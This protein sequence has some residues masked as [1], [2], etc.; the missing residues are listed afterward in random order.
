MILAHNMEA[1]NALRYT[2]NSNKKIKNSSEK[3]STGYKINRAG[4]NAAGLQISEK[5][6]AQI[7]GLERASVNAQDGISFVQT[8]DGALNDLQALIQRGRELCVQAANDT[9][10]DSDRD[11]LQKEID[12]IKDEITRICEQS[13]FN[14]IRCFPTGGT[15]PS[16]TEIS[17][18]AKY[19]ITIDR[20]AGTAVVE[21]SSTGPYSK[22][23]DKI[24]NELVPNASNQILNAFPSLDT[25]DRNIDLTF[26]LTNIDGSSGTLAYAQI[27]Y[28]LSSGDIT[29]YTLQVDISDFTN[30]DAEGT[31]P[32]AEMLESTIAH[33]MMHEVMYNALTDGMTYYG[34]ESFPNWFVEGTAQVAGGGFTTGWNSTL[35]YIE[36]SG[37]TPEIKNAQVEN[38][39][40]SYTP[41]GRP[42][43]HGYLA[44]AYLG[45]LASGEPDVSA[46]SISKGL[47]NIFHSMIADG[48]SLDEA[49][50]ANTA[51]SN[52]AAVEAAFSSPSPG[53]VAFVRELAAA[54]GAGSAIAASLST[55]GTDILNDATSGLKIMFV[56]SS[57]TIL[58]PDSGSQVNLSEGMHLQIGANS[59]QAVSVRMYDISV[60][61]LGLNSIFVSDHISADNAIDSY[62]S[63]L[64]KVSRV[65]SYYGAVQNRLEHAIA[66]SDN[67]AE[68]LQAAESGIRDTDMAKEMV[69]YSKYNILQQA[70]QAMLAQANQSKQGILNLLQ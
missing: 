54:D 27:T 2:A 55:K 7:R 1:L 44:S 66:N 65:R 32:R 67:A 47:D 39:L 30:A 24:A 61:T 57:T 58:P 68:N 9:N 23:A 53:L 52:A 49:I 63:A 40:K 13:E 56:V 64:N 8:T 38:Y 45:Y 41:S 4:D 42:Y 46:A 51:F 35:Q 6:R 34:S 14:S 3:L 50:A 25:L 37:N 36:K 26:E 20:L 60:G 19:K 43:G 11:S 28:Y 69:E 62:D 22:L 21:A 17:G 70:G 33:E 5:M 15:L 29:N 31:G 16:E 48:K 10:V 12:S 59:G 18:N